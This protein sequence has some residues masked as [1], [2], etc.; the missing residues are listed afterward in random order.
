V[1]I[2][3]D[4]CVNPRLRQAFPEDEVVTAITTQWRQIRDHRLVDAIQGRFDV[5]VT[6]D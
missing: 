3:I 5:L 4:E 1:R 2:L 6:I